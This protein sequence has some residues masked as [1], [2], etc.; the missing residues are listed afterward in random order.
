MLPIQPQINRA[1]YTTWSFAERSQFIT[2]VGQSWL[3]SAGTPLQSVNIVIYL[4]EWQEEEI[5]FLAPGQKILEQFPAN[6]TSPLFYFQREK[7]LDAYNKIQ[8]WKHLPGGADYL[9]NRQVDAGQ[10]REWMKSRP[11]VLNLQK[12][13]IGEC[14]MTRIPSEICLCTRLTRF[15][16]MNTLLR[17][18]PPEFGQLIHLKEVFLSNNRLRCLC[19]EFQQLQKLER[20]E[21]NN[22]RLEQIDPVGFL[23]NLQKLSAEKNQIGRLP[24]Q[25]EWKKLEI[26]IL[27]ENQLIDLP[28]ALYGIRSIKLLTL[29]HNGLT[30]ISE[31]I[32]QM[33]CLDSLF[34][35]YNVLT[36]LPQSLG[37]MPKLRSVSITHNQIVALPQSLVEPPLLMEILF[38]GNPLSHRPA[39]LP[40]KIWTDQ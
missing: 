16:M 11:E 37:S 30:S 2:S 14:P 5:L 39:F 34:L 26:L 23:K 29:A 33:S 13:Q 35:D 12:L 3:D 32:C 27:G 21:L 38:K 22:N 6:P 17:Q 18:L 28:D 10:L 4:L 1:S 40:A 8:F 20:L 19:P 24:P 36:A 7:W 9:K 15:M 25:M 31:K